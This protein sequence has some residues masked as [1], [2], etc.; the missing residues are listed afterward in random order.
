MV[1]SPAYSGS[2]SGWLL[3]PPSHPPRQLT[4]NDT[5]I[6]VG[7][8]VLEVISALLEA[9]SSILGEVGP[10]QYYLRIVG[11]LNSQT[12]LMFLVFVSNI[13]GDVTCV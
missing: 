2:I 12:F 11:L 1:G 3:S 6:F 9:V 5:R 13:Y 4:S 8:I 10:S 7:E